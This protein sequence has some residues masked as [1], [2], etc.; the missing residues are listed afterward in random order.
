MLPIIDASWASY[1]HLYAQAL[2]RTSTFPFWVASISAAHGTALLG[3]SRRG[4][5][6]CVL[7]DAPAS[8]RVEECARLDA[9]RGKAR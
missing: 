7:V 2:G 9:R 3:A 5:N 6:E 1:Q 4:L 8:T